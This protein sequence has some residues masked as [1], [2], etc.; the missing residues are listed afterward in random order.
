M[1]ECAQHTS[2]LE[3]PMPATADQALIVYVTCPP[4]AAETLA[5]A[6][7]EARC[8]ACVNVLPGIRS[9]YRWQG[10]VE[11]SDETLLLIKTDQ[12]HYAA[13]E[14]AVRAAHPYELPEIVAVNIGQGLPEYLQWING[15]MR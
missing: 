6:L 8:A 14:Q 4:A 1:M 12:A 3:N 10:A 11:R 13:L 7:V 2:C 5:A 15:A 9:V